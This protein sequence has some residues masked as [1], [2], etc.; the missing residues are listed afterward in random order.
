MKKVVLF[1]SLIICLYSC[2][3][4]TEQLTKEV[5]QSMEA[6]YLKNEDYTI[7]I[8]EFTLIKKNKTEYSGL[9]ETEESLKSDPSETV[10]HKYNVEVLY[11]GNTFKWE[12]KE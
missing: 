10:S 2:G 7:K 3:K 9:L 4:S 12:V 8:K 6:E 5:R 11:D 1:L